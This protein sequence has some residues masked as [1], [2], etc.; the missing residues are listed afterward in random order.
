MLYLYGYVKG[1]IQYALHINPKRIEN[2]IN[3]SADSAYGIHINDLHKSHT[4]YII[5]YGSSPIHAKSLKQSTVCDSSSYAELIAMHASIAPG[6][7]IKGIYEFIGINNVKIVIHQDNT[8]SIRTTYDTTSANNKYLDIKHSYVQDLVNRLILQVKY[9]CGDDITADILVS[10]RFGDH[11][12]KARE[13]LGI[14]PF[15]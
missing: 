14:K 2:T 9:Q 1:T 6:M 10:R 13:K 4:G 3:I 8:Q 11:F 15:M 5:Y 12:K 7:F